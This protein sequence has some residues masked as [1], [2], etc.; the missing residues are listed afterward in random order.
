MNH[1]YGIL[2]DYNGVIADDE[3]LQEAAFAE[4]MKS[5]GVDL[6]HEEYASFCMGRTDPEGFMELQKAYPE[7]M[8]NTETNK[9]CKL[10]TEKYF[11]LAKSKSV[12][13]KG[14]REVIDRLFKDF[15][16]GI[17]TSSSK[18]EFETVMG[19]EGILDRF[20]IFITAEDIEK[21]KPNP[22]PYLKGLAALQTLKENTVAIEDSASGVKSAKAAGIKCL[23]V[24]HTTPEDRLRDA[25]KIV[26]SITEIDSSVIRQ[27]FLHK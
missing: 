23:A 19:K 21:G 7:R 26:S 5:F 25:D 12:I 14:V 6:S 2:F 11:E 3:A 1:K 10:K 20:Q 16:L 13:Y 18:R 15:A 8:Q 17:V 4:V 24:L 9:L 22:D 27:V